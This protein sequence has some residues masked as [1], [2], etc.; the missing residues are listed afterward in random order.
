MGYRGRAKKLGYINGSY[1]LNPI[2]SIYRANWIG[3][4]APTYFDNF[5]EHGIIQRAVYTSTLS[6]EQ[7]FKIQLIVDNKSQRGQRTVRPRHECSVGHDRGRNQD[8]GQNNMVA[9]S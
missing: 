3:P 8:I 4:W 9:G 7:A 2:R 1:F 6:I 5:N